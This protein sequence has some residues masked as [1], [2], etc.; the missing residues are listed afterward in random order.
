MQNVFSKT[1]LMKRVFKIKFQLP[2]GMTTYVGDGEE[3]ETQRDITFDFR[4]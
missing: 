4:Y 2:K 3:E 1:K